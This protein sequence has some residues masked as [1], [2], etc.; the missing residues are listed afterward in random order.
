MYKQILTIVRGMTHSADEAFTDRHALPIL[1]QQIRDSARAVASARR[2]VAIAIA[3]SE[4]EREQ[5]GALKARMTDLED[6]VVAA[7]EQGKTELAREAAETIAVLEADAKAS[8]EAQERFAVEIERLK[9]SVRQAEARLLEVQRGQRLA[10]AT[11]AAQDMQEKVAADDL[12]SLAD[13]E[14]T[15][16]RLRRRQREFD[17]TAKAHADLGGPNSPERMSERLAEAGCGE[18]LRSS[19]D[20]VIARLNARRAK[21]DGAD[22]AQSGQT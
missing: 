13:A 5:D 6:R 7:L 16:M 3:Q 20:D 9:Q 2:A 21:S 15:L 14:A 19:A 12:S 10:S 18:P 22:G 1:Q 17:L 8:A 11:Q 4:Q